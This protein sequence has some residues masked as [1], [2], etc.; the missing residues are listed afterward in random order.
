MVNKQELK[1]EAEY[2]QRASVLEVGR[3][4]VLRMAAR[5][6]PL[7]KTL[8]ALCEKALIYNPDMLCSVL[9]LDSEQD[10]L[11]PIAAYGIPEFYSQALEGVQI[12]LGVG[13]CGTAAFTK[14]R[15][16]VE[17]ISTHPYWTQYKD[18]AMSAGLMACWS[19]PIRGADD[20][21]YGTFA[22]YYH[23][24]IAP[25][26]EDLHFIEVSANLAALVFENFEYK[27]QL[28]KANEQLQ[29]SLDERTKELQLANSELQASIESQK[30]KFVSNVS[31]EK[32]QTTKSLVVGVAHEISTP[33]GNSIMA[34][35]SAESGIHDLLQMVNTN[36]RFSKS[37]LISNLNSIKSAVNMTQ[38]GLHRVAHLLDQFK[39]VDAT[40]TDWKAQNINLM[41]YFHHFRTMIEAILGEHKLELDIQDI[42]VCL[43]TEGLT[44]IFLHL[45]DNSIV[46]GFVNKPQGMINITASVNGSELIINY[47]DD[48]V[49]INEENNKKV[50]E[51]FFVENRNA[52]SV[53]LGLNIINNIVRQS[54]KGQILLKKSPVNSGVRFE[55]K[56]PLEKI[57]SDFEE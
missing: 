54:L 50:F 34:S 27:A 24:P 55:I 18:L 43:S 19:E 48:G 1:Q 17:D 47:A 23:Q 15:V 11:H 28:T 39:K 46:H 32:M 25:S 13:S 31:V 20:R 33:V 5:G 57:S 6:E 10:T 37:E 12:G 30:T 16:I 4:E 7:D 29:Q 35:D 53:G 22:M 49:G 21:I 9:R 38:S 2:W 42:E 36:Q 26:E 3:N 56:V 41:G 14:E 40:A 52:N 51:P 45:I 44:Q 8:S